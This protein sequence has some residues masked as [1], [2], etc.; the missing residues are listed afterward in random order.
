MEDV[1]SALPLQALPDRMQGASVRQMTKQIAAMVPEIA[2][3]Q[4][5]TGGSHRAASCG[6]REQSSAHNPPGIDDWTP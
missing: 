1:M 3:L 5:P 2:G 6:R 4:K